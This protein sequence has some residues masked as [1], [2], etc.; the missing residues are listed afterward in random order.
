[1]VLTVLLTLVLI[2]EYRLP[3]SDFVGQG[4]RLRLEKRQK[5][6]NAMIKRKITE[7]AT[8]IYVCVGEVIG[9][10]GNIG[11]IWSLN[12]RHCLVGS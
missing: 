1:M 3:K 9:G 11:F 12:T 5:R 4:E 7:I 8:L 10:S 2:C 6:R